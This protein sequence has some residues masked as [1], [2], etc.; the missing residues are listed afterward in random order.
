M[1]TSRKS[2]TSSSNRR[3]LPRYSLRFLGLSVLIVAGVVI[4]ACA[5][6][7]APATPLGEDRFA[8]LEADG[9]VGTMVEQHQ[10]MMDQMR[11]NAT[12]QMLELMN[13][14]PMWQMMRSGEYLRLLEEHE[15]TST[16]CWQEAVKESSSPT[17]S[18]SHRRLLGTLS[19]WH[20]D[21]RNDGHALV[22][23]NPCSV[24]RRRR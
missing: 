22:A 24:V 21:A 11:A 2:P 3:D 14:D 19:A 7:D 5:P 13:N 9:D 20:Q 1:K 15:A 16:A 12:P 4:G 17:A 10:A 6:A 23:R 18:R 8:V